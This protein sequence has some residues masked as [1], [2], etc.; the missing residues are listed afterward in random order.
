MTFFPK[1]QCSFPQQTIDQFQK[2]T[3]L[4]QWAADVALAAD[5]M[6]FI[7]AKYIVFIIQIQEIKCQILELIYLCVCE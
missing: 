7:H 4:F 3:R 5:G 1:A 6:F 2:N